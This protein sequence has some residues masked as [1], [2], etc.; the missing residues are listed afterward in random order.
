MTLILQFLANSKKPSK[1]MVEK[2]DNN[3]GFEMGTWDFAGFIDYFVNIIGSEI[4]L[5]KKRATG[6]YSYQFKKEDQKKIAKDIKNKMGEDIIVLSKKKV[7]LLDSLIIRK[8]W[9]KRLFNIFS[10]SSNVYWFGC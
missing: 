1:K 4:N 10:S 7:G 6:L 9:A 8:K 5:G 2:P 3:G